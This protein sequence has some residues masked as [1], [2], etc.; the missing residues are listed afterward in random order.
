MTN[1]GATTLALC[2]GINGPR[3][4]N[5]VLLPAYPA[6]HSYPRPFRYRSKWI[7]PAVQALLEDDKKRKLLLKQEVAICFVAP[8]PDSQGGRVIVPIRSGGLTTIAQHGDEWFFYFSV[9]PFFS[10]SKGFSAVAIQESTV[11]GAS[12]TLAKLM[13]PGLLPAKED[14][15]ES[16]WSQFVDLL[17]RDPLVGEG[18]GAIRIRRSIHVKL[19]SLSSA[20]W[21]GAARLGSVRRSAVAGV[22][23][24]F[25]LKE[26]RQYNGLVLTRIPILIG[27]DTSFHSCSLAVEAPDVGRLLTTHLVIDGNYQPLDVAF[28]TGVRRRTSTRVTLSAAETSDVNGEPLYTQSVQYETRIRMAFWYRVVFSWMPWLFI[29]L[30]FAVNSLVGAWSSLVLDS[31]KDGKTPPG[32]LKFL[33]DNYEVLGVLALLAAVVGVALAVLQ[34][35]R[36]SGD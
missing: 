16:A 30:A 28:T 13:E 19:H 6:G 20:G 17:A 4:D 29:A 23:Q 15:E 27:T 26:K 9:G 12:G 2:F 32:L 34:G 14:N 35:K 11:S 7:D 5:A 21:L 25:K 33:G 1:T 8:S 3:S 18:Q 24:G 36:E 10:Q 22:L 31:I